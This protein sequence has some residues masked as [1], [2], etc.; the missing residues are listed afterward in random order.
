MIKNNATF[1]SWR[2]NS[3]RQH[4]QDFVLLLTVQQLFLQ[5]YKDLAKWLYYMSPTMFNW[6]LHFTSKFPWSLLVL[7]AYGSV[8]APFNYAIVIFPLCTDLACLW[9]TYDWFI[10]SMLDTLLVRL[11]CMKQSGWLLAL[12][13]QDNG[14]FEIIWQRSWYCVSFICFSN[15]FSFSFKHQKETMNAEGRTP[16]SS[17]KLVWR[18]N[19][20][21]RYY[22]HHPIILYFPIIS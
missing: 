5:L 4:K 2:S 19:T 20:N 17:T 12:L 3:Y 10:I 11:V 1:D 21:N 18:S 8:C 22:S 9:G 13:Y 6:L 16:I 15:L 14:A 7:R